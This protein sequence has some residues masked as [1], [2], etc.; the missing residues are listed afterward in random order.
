MKIVGLTGGIGSGKSVVS[1]MF[2]RLGA[3]VIGAD[4]LAREVVNPGQAA[5]KE[6]VAHFGK[7]VLNADQS[8]N[9]ERLASIVFSDA[10]ARRALEE[11]T[12]PRIRALFDE[13]VRELQSKG[14]RVIIYDVP[15]FFES[16]LDREIR[17]VVVVYAEE[18]VRLER[19]KARDGL[20]DEE[21]LSRT[22]SQMPLEE[23]KGLADYVIDNSGTLEETKSQVTRVWQEL[24]NDP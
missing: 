2:A 21:I 1:G 9:R 17:P 4:Q 12:H 24:L 6:I 14:C 19:V 15:L 16:H 10:E 7:E 5:W 8:L 3:E 18:S 20:S 11:I 22:K 23:K 13:R